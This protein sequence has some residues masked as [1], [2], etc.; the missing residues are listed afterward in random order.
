[1]SVHLDKFI[2]TGKSHFMCEDYIL[3]GPDFVIL[4]DGCSAAHNSDVGARI[5]CHAAANTLE[6]YRF[7]WDQFEWFGLGQRIIH[8]AE[9][10]ATAM[11]LDD[12]CL[13]ATLMIVLND[14]E[15]NKIQ[16]FAYGDGY[17]F[18]VNNDG[19]VDLKHIEFVDGK[20]NN[21]PF[22][23]LY[24]LD[25]KAFDLYAMQHIRQRITSVLDEKLFEFDEPMH[26]EHQI[27]DFRTVLISSDGLSSFDHR[28]P[29]LEVAQESTTYKS[30]AG[31]FLQRR[32]VR[33][34]KKL[35][36]QKLYH[37]DDITIG[38]FHRED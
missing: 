17:V 25:P 21:K 32:M 10:M 2:A 6:R 15:K 22:Y 33:M 4:S 34:I 38:G 29:P 28:P 24:Y 13:A 36:K 14:Y 37:Q 26:W 7:N 30:T 9:I 27:D 23:L 16:I 20:Q 35:A 3:S 5:L 8:Q 1:M 11:F 18:Y 19:T 12:E 31:N